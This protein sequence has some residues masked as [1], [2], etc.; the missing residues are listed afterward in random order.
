MS[1]VASA[2][3]HIHLDSTCACRSCGGGCEGGGASCWRCGGGGVA[4]L[5]ADGSRSLSLSRSRLSVRCDAEGCTAAAAATAARLRAMC[6]AAAWRSFSAVVSREGDMVADGGPPRRSSAG[7]LQCRHDCISSMHRE[8]HLY[9]T[10]DAS[11]VPIWRGDLCKC[12]VSVMSG[13]SAQL[14][15]VQVLCMPSQA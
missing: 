9:A 5:L 1:S 11:K 8:G 3:C 4:C 7:C 2:S 13:T 12:A 10:L 6:S 14:W 15:H